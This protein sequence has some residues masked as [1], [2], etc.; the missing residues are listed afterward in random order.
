[1]LT[2]CHLPHLFLW[3]TPPYPRI[4]PHN[5]RLPNPHSELRITSITMISDTSYKTVCIMS[6]KNCRA[7]FTQKKDFITCPV[8]HIATIFPSYDF[9]P[10]LAPLV[11]IDSIDHPRLHSDPS[12][13]STFTCRH[14]VWDTWRVEGG[15]VT[16]M[17][18]FFLWHIL[19]SFLLMTDHRW[20]FFSCFIIDCWLT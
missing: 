3:L 2:P 15:I 4:L 14:Q 8:P 19:L 1:M 6:V 17:L 13:R 18:T 16:F 12:H 10:S 5:R 20:H 9:H 11:A 7:I